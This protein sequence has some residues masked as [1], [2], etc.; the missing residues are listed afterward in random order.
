MSTDIPD[1]A[2]H[3]LLKESFQIP[4]LREFISLALRRDATHGRWKTPCD[5]REKLHMTASNENGLRRAGR[6]LEVTYAKKQGRAPKWA[7]LVPHVKSL[8]DGA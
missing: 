4:R 7:M 5:V 2:P 6:C 3:N 8:K 1:L